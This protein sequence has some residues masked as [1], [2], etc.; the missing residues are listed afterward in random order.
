MGR[1]RK[2]RRRRIIIRR[3]TIPKIFT[4]PNCESRCVNVIVKKSEGK[5]TVVC[6]QCGLT[7]V[8]DYNPLLQPVDYFNKF[9]DDFYEGKITP[10]QVGAT[11]SPTAE[12]PP[13]EGTEETAEEEVSE[14]EESA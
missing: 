4:C 7:A 3:R 8:Y 9:V 6:G 10:Q 13:E 5:V 14:V 12:V 1:R 2:S 11:P